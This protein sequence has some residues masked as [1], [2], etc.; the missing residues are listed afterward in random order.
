MGG[1]VG[2]QRSNELSHTTNNSY[3]HTPL[4]PGSVIPLDLCSVTQNGERRFA[5][6]SM[7]FGLMADI[8][9]GTEDMRYWN[10]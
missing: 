1:A 8:D 6:L 4:R 3:T 10:P 2:C 7:A 9:L 5:F